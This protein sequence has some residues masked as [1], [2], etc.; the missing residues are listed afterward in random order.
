MK[1]TSKWIVIVLVLASIFSF[2]GVSVYGADSETANQAARDLYDLGLFIGTGNDGQGQ[3]VFELE[4]TPTRNEAVTMLVRLLG[5]EEDALSRTWDIPFTD[6]DEWA[7]PYIGYAYANG[8]TNGTSATTFDGSQPVSAT[9]YLT[10][11][12]RSLGYISGLD[13]EWDRAWIL[14]DNLNITHGEYSD[15]SIFTRGD[16]AIVSRNALDAR[17]K[18]QDATLLE[19]YHHGIRSKTVAE[20]EH[21]FEV[22]YIDV[23]Q[24]DAALIICD[25]HAML[26]DGGTA[27]NSSRIYTYL[28]E[29]DVTFADAK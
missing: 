29:H 7:V 22:H 8:L 26:V 3:P 9:Q 5:R 18:G 12:L 16:A 23:G 25:G 2:A 10:F 24:G 6:V 28:K 19:A 14:T 15:S 27:D 20:V 1:N 13:Y 4:R 21:G 11:L 17:L